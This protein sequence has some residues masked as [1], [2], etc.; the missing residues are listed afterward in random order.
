[1]AMAR[2]RA[3]KAAMRE[4]NDLRDAG[5]NVLD[6]RETKRRQFAKTHGTVLMIV[7]HDGSSKEVFCG[8]Y[9]TRYFDLQREIAKNTPRKNGI[10]AIQDENGEII[11]SHNFQPG[12]YYKIKELPKRHIP[13]IYPL[14]HHKWEFKRYHGM[15]KDWVDP[16]EAARL[17]EEARLQALEEARLQKLKEEK[18]AEE[19]ERRKA[20]EMKELIGGDEEWDDMLAGED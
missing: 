2:L 19:A 3:A 20:E 12:H 17:A 18:E 13:L 1:M 6:E 11:S 9:F 15:P 4:A 10:F 14:V 16:V 8:D 5:V 7:F